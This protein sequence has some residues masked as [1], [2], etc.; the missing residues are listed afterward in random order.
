MKVP[1]N[2][3]AAL[4]TGKA[5]LT[6][7]IAKFEGNQTEIVEDPSQHPKC[8]EVLQFEKGKEAQVIY[9]KKA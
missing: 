8:L 1:G 3:V 5:R 9:K 6:Y 2:V 7:Q 4:I